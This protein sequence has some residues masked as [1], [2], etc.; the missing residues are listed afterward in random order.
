[1][2]GRMKM[3]MPSGLTSMLKDGYKHFSGLEEAIARNIEACRQLAAITRTSLG[4]NGMNKLVVN[5]L[6]K[7]FVTSDAA[8]IVQEL[9][10]AHPAARMI[11]MAAKMQEQ[12]FGDGTNLVLTMAGE[13]LSQ[14]ESLLRLG[15]HPSEIIEGYGKAADATYKMLDELVVSTLEN[16]RDLAALKAAIVPVIGSKIGGYEELLAGL[17]AEAIHVRLTLRGTLAAS[18]RPPTESCLP[19]PVVALVRHHHYRRYHAQ[20]VF[21]PPPKKPSVTVDN[22]RVA[23]LIGGAASDSQVV[24]GVVVQRDSEGSVKQ[25]TD[26]KIVVFGCSIEAAAT[27]TRGTVIIKNADDLMSYN[28]GEERMIEEAIKGVAATGAKVVVAGGAISEIALHFL[29]KYGLMAIKVQ[30]KFELRRLCKAVGATALVRLGPPMPEE[31]G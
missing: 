8:T 21:P 2:S 28:K 18:Q 1:M 31:L 13:L 6:E 30:S 22:V 25:V 3:G 5:H 24:R 27:E 20:A 12:E 14:A 15:V 17:V 11:T 23:K 9:E 26:A 4:P 16:P 29:E 7:I 19:H 10:V